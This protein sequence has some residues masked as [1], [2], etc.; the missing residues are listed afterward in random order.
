MGNRVKK[1]P[2]FWIVWNKD[3]GQMGDYPTLDIA[4]EASKRM[5]LGYPG[6][7]FVVLESL[8]DIAG[9]VEVSINEHEYVEANL[10]NER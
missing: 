4:T 5:A 2:R 3:R 10:E 7:D 8:F 1:V 6:E 9:N